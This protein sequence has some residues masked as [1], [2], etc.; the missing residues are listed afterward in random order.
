VNLAFTE[1]RDV[2]SPRPESCLMADT[3]SPSRDIRFGVFEVD[4]NACELRKKGS[5]V[6]LQRQPFTLLSILLDPPGKVV[7]REE[8]RQRLWPAEVNVDFDRSLNKAMVKLR[9]ALGDSSDSP[10]YIETLPGI[11]YRFIGMLSGAPAP[12]VSTEPAQSRV[13]AEK[14]AAPPSGQTRRR[15]LG[16][17]LAA[18]L[19][20]AWPLSKL[21]LQRS[22]RGNAPPVAIR[23]L[24]VLPLTNL[25]GDPGQDFFADGMTDELTTDLG[26]VSALRVISRTSATQY[27]G[28]K[29]QLGEIARELNVDAVV[30]GTVARSGSHVRITANL[31]QASPEKHLWAESYESEV[32][33][34]FTIQGRIAQA[35]T[36]EIQVKLTQQEQSLLA[37]ARPVNPE[38]QDLYLR[39]LYIVRGSG[40]AE[41]SDKA[42]KYFQQAIEKDPDYA[43]AYA[44]L[45][46]TYSVWLPGM[47]HTPRELMPKAKEF[48][49]KALSLD[50]T[51]SQPHCVLGMI[52]LLYDWDWAAAEEEYKQTLALNPNYFGV[53][54]WHSRGLVARGSTEEGVA[55]A[56]RTLALSPSPLSWDYPIWV[57]VLA[58]RQDLANDRAKALIEVAPEWVWAHYAM[59]MVY[60]SQGQLEEAAKEY[61]K[62]DEL[63]GTDSRKIAQLRRAMAKS[64]AQGYWRQTLENFKESAKS[65]YAPPV[66]VA[67]ACVRVG[68]KNC[69]FAWLEKGFQERDDLMINLKVEPV[70]YGLHSDPRFLD[71]IRRVGIP[72]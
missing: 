43:A 64:G 37:A 21:E 65:G 69:A 47:T 12:T 55:E 13:E 36:R 45:A 56:K 72:Q 8:L 25:S 23:S 19:L 34:A 59:A 5:R 14:S 66:L 29:K 52:D 62:C 17:G 48:A 70:F 4:V 10:L 35:L 30:E 54:E 15:F 49:R 68:D 24:A 42:I 44:A 58:R 11:G 31:I 39:G 3:S 40:S 2:Y 53:Y 33:D 41:S 22:A 1:R 63:F 50:N 32:G 7:K 9:E 28:T 57:F 60:E 26:K 18:T 71:L 16:I 51:L 38:A 61:L 67:E 6:K 46:H 27:K 20:L